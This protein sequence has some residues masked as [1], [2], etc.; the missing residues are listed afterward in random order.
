MNNEERLE[1]RLARR[2][3]K[4]KISITPYP[5]SNA[6]LGEVKGSVLRYMFPCDGTI[7]KGIIKLDKKPKG[8][9]EVNISLTDEQGKSSK[10]FILNSKE[11]STSLDLEVK[12][13]NCL[14]V[15]VESAEIVNEFWISFLWIPTS[16][17]IA[18]VSVENEGI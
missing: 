3:T 13:G 16:K 17:N 7:T 6:I 5:I 9:V 2:S 18:K 8:D 4:E 12:E 14:N 15:E 1:A 10:L 11:F